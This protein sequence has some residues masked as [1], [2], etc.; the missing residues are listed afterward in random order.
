VNEL[1]T[2]PPSAAPGTRP[3]VQAPASTSDN[4]SPQQQSMEGGERAPPEQTEAQAPRGHD[5]AVVVSAKLTQLAPGAELTVQVSGTN[6]EG[7]LRLTSGLGT[8]VTAP[9]PELAAATRLVLRIVAVD[10]TVKALVLA[11]DGEAR[12]QPPT[13]ELTLTRLA[14]VSVPAEPASPP[15]PALPA[16]PTPTASTYAPA[17]EAV[18]QLLSQSAPLPAIAG[19]T[20]QPDAPAPPAVVAPGTRVTATI[21]GERS[22]A[23]E[24]EPTTAA[25]ARASAP[26]APLHAGTE[27]VLSLLSH[28]PGGGEVSAESAGPRSAI[29]AP[30]APAQL[31]GLK[32]EAVVTAEVGQRAAEVAQSLTRV[33]GRI[34]D[35][36]EAT[37]PVLLQTGIGVIEAQMP[38]SVAV[39]DVLTTQVIT[40]IPAAT[41][42][43][44]GARPLPPEDFQFLAA[45]SQGWPA[46][47]EAL[48]TLSQTA[49]GIARTLGQT[50]IPGVRAPLGPSL[51]FFLVALRLAAPREWLG[52]EAAAALNRAGRSD[53]LRRL[54]D[55]MA[56]L[57][58]LASNG[59][60]NQWR[61]IVLPFHDGQGLVPL[62]LYVHR[63]D[64]DEARN[65]D[66]PDTG[67]DDDRKR[68]SL[69][70]VLDL[71]LSRLGA[72]QL[73][74]LVANER[75]DLILRSRQGLDESLRQT[76]TRIFHDSNASTGLAG[77]IVFET[78]APF[79]VAPIHDLAPAA[80]AP[81]RDT[82]I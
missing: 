11:I 22:T 58:N 34:G 15:A 20:A 53:L 37:K 82:R 27:L 69:R 19:R 48:E 32:I 76:L 28:R 8:L 26:P 47:D 14:R 74:G 23:P 33:R 50:V 66:D 57:L 80:G 31:E 49:P 67:G 60:A 72:L 41:G 73:D 12:Q 9:E 42:V 17:P 64:D 3:Q 56:R 78:G 5:P 40:A 38:A 59:P 39:G 25:S 36:A 43:A 55:D 52:P 1:T 68:G 71:D 81:G 75:F 4:P 79:P 18:A 13:I 65:R 7:L 35:T 30:A 29:A 45:A 61:P 24:A 2:P 77:D 54:G 46:L 70:F 10:A 16:N 62:T 63:P 21:V 6:A 44:D 51:L